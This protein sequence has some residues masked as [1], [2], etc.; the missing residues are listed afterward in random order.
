MEK[1]ILP[2]K[3]NRNAGYDCLAANYPLILN[4][5]RKTNK[6]Q[7]SLPRTH[8]DFDTNDMDFS[9][10]GSKNIVMIVNSLFERALK[11]INSFNYPESKTMETRS[12]LKHIVDI[13][14]IPAYV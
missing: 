4:T 9:A 14:L 1:A 5:C 11:G 3:S 6:F 2:A 8:D 10:P 12:G 7:L 13:D